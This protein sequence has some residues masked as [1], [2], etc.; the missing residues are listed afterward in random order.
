MNTLELRD[1]LNKFQRNNIFK[2]VFA[3]DTIPTN[4]S[5]PA[6]FII[7]LAP[8][9]DPGTHWVA[10]YIDINGTCEYFDSYGLKPTNK[11]IMYFIKFHCK[12]ININN[13][14][15]QHINSRVCGMYSA[16]YIVY[17]LKKKSMDEYC[18][19][20]CKNTFV[21]DIV[22]QNLFSYFKRLAY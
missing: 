18:N 12:S 21:N 13:V 14:Q 6:A 9:S 22:V 17:K 4:F 8:I 2:G 20:F 5:L 1:F 16:L 7:N 19:K 11:Y 3:C 15:L 10:L